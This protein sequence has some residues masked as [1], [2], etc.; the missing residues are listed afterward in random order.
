MPE[1][2]I[3]LPNG[4]EIKHFL[5]TEAPDDF[6]LSIGRLENCDLVVPIP[7]VSGLHAHIVK[8]SL[9]YVL[10][11][12]DST[13]GLV[14]NGEKELSVLL[15]PGK[16]VF[17][18]EAV[19]KYDPEGGNPGAADAPIREE[20]KAPE[21]PA[22]VPPAPVQ[23]VPAWHQ[24]PV[25]AAPVPVAEPLGEPE[26]IELPP[27]QELIDNHSDEDEDGQEVRTRR[28][29]AKSY[30]LIILCYLVVVFG[31]AFATGLIYKHYSMTKELLPYKWLGI[32]TPKEDFY[33]RAEDNKKAIKVVEV[34]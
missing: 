2:T 12:A 14:V 23:E 26:R 13:N 27:A 19:L 30:Y 5:P 33:K 4:S 22:P 6:Q 3:I 9:G 29:V 15:E 21:M 25:V 10:R 20:K 18:G 28:V 7:S 1:I 24:E 17:M 11:D 8:L 32:D 31:V 34:E 16:C